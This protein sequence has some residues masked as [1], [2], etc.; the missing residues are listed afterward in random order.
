M[1][2]EFE[3]PSAVKPRKVTKTKPIPI[4]WQEEARR[5]IAQ[6]IEDGVIEEV[7]DEATD[8]V[9]PAFFVE[10]PNGKLRLV[11]D[12]TY[13]NRFVKRPIHP[14]PSALDIITDIP[15][16]MTHFAKLD[17]PPGLSPSPTPPR[18]PPFDDFPSPFREIPLLPRPYGPQIYERCLL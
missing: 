12:F 7:N 11:T 8:W 5:T 2:I 18:Q 14:F 6:L 10:K 1:I 9:S 16:G 15:A 4:H 3:N 17:A 13:L